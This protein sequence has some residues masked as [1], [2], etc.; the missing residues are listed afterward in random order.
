M[1]ETT[2]EKRVLNTN[3]LGD[4]DAESIVFVHGIGGSLSNWVFHYSIFLMRD[5]RCIAYDL[6]GHGNSF[7]PKKG[8]RLM[9]HAEDL[10]TIHIENSSKCKKIVAHSY[11][12]NIALKWAMKYG[13]ENDIIIILDTPELPV[14]S[15]IIHSFVHDIQAVLNKDFTPKSKFAVQLTESILDKKSEINRPA[16]NY[17]KRLSQ[18]SD[19]NFENEIVLDQPFTEKELMK[20]SAKVVLIYA[21]KDYNIPYASRLMTAIPN[22][23]L[24]TLDADH[25]LVT[26]HS[27]EIVDF[28]KICFKQTN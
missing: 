13:T 25:Q 19:T 8:Y 1:L 17:K 9:D 26:T 5:Y 10:E 22:C 20:I 7:Y 14:P 18:L 21:Q 24:F 23:Q 11:G 16:Q 3:C 15:D 4:K 6:R 27:K 12:G 28:I 2:I